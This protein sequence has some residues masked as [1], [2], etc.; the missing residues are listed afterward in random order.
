MTSN[1]MIKVNCKR[2][3]PF[4]KEHKQ[5]DTNAYYLGASPENIYK[6]RTSQQRD[7]LSIFFLS[8]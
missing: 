4:H 3:I 8:N 5:K 2:L 1:G 6:C 7:N